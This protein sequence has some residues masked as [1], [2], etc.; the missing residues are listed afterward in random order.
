MALN[1]GGRLPGQLY[2]QFIEYNNKDYVVGTLIFN[3]N[4]IK[5][6]FDKDDFDKVSE[7]AWHFASGAYISSAFIHNS[8]KKEL[9]LHN[10]IM[11]RLEFTGKGSIESVDHINRNGLDN[12]KENLRI[13][14][15]SEQNINQNKR[16]RSIKLPEGCDINIDDI[17]T[18]IWYIRPVGITNRH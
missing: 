4:D 3:K 6:V 1:K 9:Y 13:I 18:H 8:K 16:V 15:Q 10:L 17:P 2:Y 7:R 5:F 14:S 12:R 11:N